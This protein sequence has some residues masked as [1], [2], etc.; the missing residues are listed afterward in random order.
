MCSIKKVNY[1]DSY[2]EY[3][4]NI[5]KNYQKALNEK[6]GIETF[7]TYEDYEQS[8]TD[9]NKKNH[10]LFKIAKDISDSE[11][12]SAYITE[13]Y[14][15]DI[16]AQIEYYNTAFDS[17]ED[18]K[19]IYNYMI[20]IDNYQET[21]YMNYYEKI[22]YAKY[23][24]KYDKANGYKILLSTPTLKSGKLDIILSKEKVQYNGNYLEYYN[25]SG[26]KVTAPL[27]EYKKDENGN[28]KEYAI[29]SELIDGYIKE[30]NNYYNNI[31]QRTYNHF[32]IIC[33]ILFL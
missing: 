30:C 32:S 27:I 22:E 28:I 25:P 15:N 14:K 9:K 2:E 29:K 5:P 20:H 10:E 6:N 8:V 33:K 24:M 17:E 31:M 1:Y 12:F 7:D 11:K 13:N 18:R 4:Q 3:E 23:L 16:D 26:I 21:K 19:N